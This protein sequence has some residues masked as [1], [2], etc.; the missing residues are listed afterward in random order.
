MENL[1][2]VICAGCAMLVVKYFKESM[3]ETVGARRNDD[4]NMDIVRKAI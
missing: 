1:Y 2:A 3:F 4:V